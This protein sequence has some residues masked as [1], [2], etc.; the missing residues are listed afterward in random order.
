MQTKVGDFRVRV[1]DWGRRERGWGLEEEE[2][3]QRVASIAE[4]WRAIQY[5]N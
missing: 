2:K 5:H 1:R 3:E 4:K